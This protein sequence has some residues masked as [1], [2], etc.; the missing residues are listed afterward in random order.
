MKDWKK[1]LVTTSTPIRDAMQIIDTS[2]LQIALVV[3]HDARLVGVVTDGDIRRGLLRGI[4]LEEPVELIFKRDFTAV[5]PQISRN[6]ILALMKRKELRQIPV[7]DH[8]GRVVGLKILDDL[9]PQPYKENWVVIM[10]GGMGSRLQPLTNEV[11]KPLLKVG[12]KPL[13]ETIIRSFCNYGFRKF[14]ISVNYRAEMIETCLGD[15]SQWGV[16][17][18][19]LKESTRMDTAGAL[20][21]LPEKPSHA[22]IVMNGDVLT[23]INFHQ[24]M[25]FHYVHKAKAT[26]CVK[27]YRI[28]VPYGV[29]T[30]DEHRLT[31]INE[32]PAQSFFVNAGIYVIEPEMLA[33]ISPDQPCDMISFFE[34]IIHS[35]HDVVAFPIREYWVDIGKMEDLHRA[36]GEYDKHFRD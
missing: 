31:N 33:L 5:T 35:N 28:Q 8:Q 14:F 36:N 13:L 9:I 17:I 6:E 22:L 32:K 27:E 11:P 21:L 25:D 26:L 30:M 3:D 20:G 16:E 1:T 29:I 12:S 4:S 10:A 18:S 34:R 15:G 7:L 2:S 19:Y 24:L 23:K